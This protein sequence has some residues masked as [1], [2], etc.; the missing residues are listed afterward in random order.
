MSFKAVLRLTLRRECLADPEEERTAIE[1]QNTQGIYEADVSVKCG[2]VNIE[3]AEPSLGKCRISFP[4]D[5]PGIVT[6]HQ[7]F[8]GSHDSLTLV[9]EEGQRHISINRNDGDSLEITT[10]CRSLQNTILKNGKMRLAYNSE[11][12]G[13]RVEKVA[14]KIDLKKIK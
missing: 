6:L 1:K 7:E 8:P 9:V 3:Y 14:M 5:D 2:M 11:L 10:D 13:F 4:K 12:H